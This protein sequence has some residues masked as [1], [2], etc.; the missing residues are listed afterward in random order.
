MSGV[1]NDL[2]LGE[3]LDWKPAKTPEPVVLRGTHVLV[4]PLDAANDAAPLF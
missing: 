3:E 1:S 2:P 4:R